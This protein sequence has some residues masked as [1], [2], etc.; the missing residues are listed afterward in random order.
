MTCFLHRG[1]KEEASQFDWIEAECPSVDRFMSLINSALIKGNHFTFRRWDQ[2]N[3]SPYWVWRVNN[4][5]SGATR[6]PKQWNSMG[7][8]RAPE[9]N[10]RGGGPRRH[11]KVTGG[12]IH[13]N[14]NVVWD[15][16]CRVLMCFKT[17]SLSCST[18]PSPCWALINQPLKA[19][20]TWIALHTMC[21][22]VWARQR[23]KNLW[24][25]HLMMADPEGTVL[26]ALC[27]MLLWLAKSHYFQ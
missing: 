5:K 26:S 12:G 4:A 14:A 20:V 25:C 16:Y 9:Q 24:R 23:L 10:V 15:I 22:S 6:R 7:W 1:K 8:G 13:Q 3:N 17:G 27:V 19:D 11:K 18:S 21:V 2:P